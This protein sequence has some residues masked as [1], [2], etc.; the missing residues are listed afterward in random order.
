MR[1]LEVAGLSVGGEPR[2]AVQNCAE[3]PFQ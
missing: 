1:V 2:W 3:R